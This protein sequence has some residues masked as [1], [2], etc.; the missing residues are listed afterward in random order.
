MVPRRAGQ[1]RGGRAVGQRGRGRRQEVP[2][3]QL[4]TQPHR[5]R[6]LLLGFA[7]RSGHFTNCIVVNLLRFLKLSQYLKNIPHY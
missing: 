6:N 7:G 4:G 3:G 2:P 5:A 1:V